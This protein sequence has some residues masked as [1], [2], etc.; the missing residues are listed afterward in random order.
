MPWPPAERGGGLST[1]MEDASVSPTL[2]AFFEALD[3][4]S[5]SIPLDELEPRL[6]ALDL[7]L[8][9]LREFAKFSPDHY[10]RN[11]IHEGPAYQALIL[12][13]ANGQRSP[14]H[15]HRGSACGVRIIH[16][17]ATETLFKRGANGIIPAG[18]REMPQ[19]SVC[20]S[21][22]ADIHE[23]SN[24]QP[25]G[26]NL[27]TLHIYSPPLLVMGTYSLTEA[28]VGE[29]KDPVFESAANRPQRAGT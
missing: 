24:L 20:G 4:Y 29:F 23:M 17:T 8:D 9:D 16:G 12:C 14:I 18:M 28:T 10:R 21:Y 5:G 22:D 7:S 26:T 3:R 13:W 19:G 6:R 11:L 25:S 27:V 2:S 15:D 1:S